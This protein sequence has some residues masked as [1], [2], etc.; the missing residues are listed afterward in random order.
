MAVKM[1]LHII[2]LPIQMGLTTQEYMT[3]PSR[4]KK[5]PNWAISLFLAMPLTSKT[6]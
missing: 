6:G 3:L 1:E 5:L 4:Y 2:I